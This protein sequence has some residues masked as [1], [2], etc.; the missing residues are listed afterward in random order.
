MYRYAIITCSDRGSLGE[1]QDLSA[2]EI[3]GVMSK[4]TDYKKEFYTV[5]PDE[6]AVILKTL[7][8]CV[9]DLKVDL[10]ITTGGT[11][12]SER[13]VTPEVT[14][15]YVDKLVPGLA[16]HMRAK[17]ARITPHGLLSRGITGIKEKTLI[18]NLPG[19]PKGAGENLSFIIDAI[20]HA[21]GIMTGNEKECGQKR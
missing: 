17:S 4:N 6:D 20:P 19:S 10:V 7:K 21:L 3:E 15:G 16:E 18:I 2:V 9:E 1:R 13:D 14:R 11:G 8:H 12:L 5:I